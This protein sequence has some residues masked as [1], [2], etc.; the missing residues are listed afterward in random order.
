MSKCF[1]RV[2]PSPCSCP[3]TK[4]TATAWRPE[5]SCPATNSS[6]TGCIL[7]LCVHLNLN[8]IGDISEGFLSWAPANSGPCCKNIIDMNLQPVAESSRSFCQVY[9]FLSHTVCG[10]SSL[11]QEFSNSKKKIVQ[12]TDT[13]WGRIF[14]LSL[15]TNR[16]W[17][18]ET[19]AEI[20]V[21][22]QRV[23]MTKVN[24]VRNAK[25][26]VESRWGDQA[27]SESKHKE[28][29][30]KKL[31]HKIIKT[32]SKVKTGKSPYT[33]VVTGMLGRIK[34]GSVKCTNWHW[35]KV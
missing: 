1:W 16:R 29:V 25:V 15:A 8:S 22:S 28:A 27:S 32:G 3:G 24:K 2:V 10:C 6:W 14:S 7:S 4:W 33:V 26:H 17:W 12:E 21:K 11:Q 9:V 19:W 13:I 23:E 35:K 20:N 31:R 5:L 18:K 30:R 34:A